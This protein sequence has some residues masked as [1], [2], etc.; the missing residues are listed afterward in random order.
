MNPKN[1]KRTDYFV[2]T[3]RHPNGLIKTQGLVSRE[4]N[5]PEGEWSS[6]N[7]SARLISR[8]D[9]RDGKKNGTWI[10][11]DWKTGMVFK[12]E[13]VLGKKKTSHSAGNI[14]KYSDLLGGFDEALRISE[15][16][17]KLG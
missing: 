16:M 6:Y 8:G 9:Y 7:L 13:Y 11:V 5:R 4:T 14:K 1:Y 17:L 10:D 12:T 15:A 2:S 3:Q